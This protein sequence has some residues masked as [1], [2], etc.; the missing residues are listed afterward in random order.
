MKTKLSFM[1]LFIAWSTFAFAEDIDVYGVSNIKVKPNVLIILDNSGSMG[2]IDVPPPY[3]PDTSYEGRYPRNTV[4]K[5]NRSRWKKYF[6]GNLDNW[7][8]ESALTTLN[9]KGYWEGKLN[10]N[11]SLVNCSPG[12][13]VET[14]AMGNYVNYTENPPSPL[15]SRMEVAKD[16]VAD[17]IYQNK[18]KVKFGLMTFYRSNGGHLL[19]KCGADTNT[20]IGEYDPNKDSQMKD[21]KQSGLGVVGELESDGMTPV[22]ETMAEAGLYFAGKKSWFHTT[23][24]KTYDPDHPNKNCQGSDSVPSYYITHTSPIENRCQKNYIILVTDGAPTAD[25]AKFKDKNY[26]LDTKLSEDQE[27]DYKKSGYSSDA[28]IKHYS[29]LDDVAYFLYNTDILPD[30]GSPG[31]N[32][33]QNVKTYTIGFKQKLPLLL[34]TATRGGGKYYQ[35]SNA[36]ELKENLK[37]FLVEI[38][39]Q[40]E[41]FTATSV[42]INRANKAY[43]G[44][45][46]YYGLFQPTNDGNW[47]GNLKKYAITD[48]GII[49]DAEGDP[50]ESEGTVVETARSFWSTSADGIGVTSGGAGALLKD[51]NDRKLYTYTG[52]ARDLTDKSNEFG[53]DN[54]VL[55][56]GTYSD[57]TNKVIN[58]VHKG[59]YS[60]DNNDNNDWP[61]ASFLH[62]QPI[63]V[64]YYKKNEEGNYIFDQSMIY[65]GSN[66]GMMHCFN[67]DDGKEMWG[68][69]PQD[70]L[71]K[72]SR[73]SSPTSLEYFVDGTPVVYDY[74]YDDDNDP[75]TSDKNKKLLVFGER[76]GGDYYT[77]LD[78]SDYN[79][80]LFEYS[81]SPDILM[82]T[83]GQETLG[84]SW[85]I[86]QPLKMATSK[87]T[88]TDVFLMA[89]GYDTNQDSMSPEGNDTKGRAV[90]AVDTRSGNLFHN[91]LFSQ[92]NYTDMTHSIIAVSGFEN[93]KTKTTTRVYAG[94]LYG[95]LFAF[96]DDIFHWD[97][98]KKDD[99]GNLK[100]KFDGMEDGVWEQKLKL[101]A[102]P[103]RKIWHAPNIVNEYFPVNITYPKGDIND[104]EENTGD[105]TTKV[106]ISENRIGDYVFFGTGDRAH[107]ERKDLLNGFYAIKNNW[108]WDNDESPE[109]IEATV[110]LDG[111]VKNNAGTQIMDL[112]DETPTTD[113]WYILDVTNELIHNNEY[114]KKAID[115]QKNR[116]WFIRLQ[117]DNGSMMGE[118]VVSSPLIFNG[119]VYFS[120]YVPDTK[121]EADNEPDPCAISGA[122]GNGYLY[123]I[124]Y[125]YGESVINFDPTNDTL[126]EYGNIKEKLDRSDRRTIFRNKG[127]PPQP[128][129]VVHEGKPTIIAGF[130]TIDPLAPVGLQRA[131]W[132]QLN[133]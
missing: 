67:D 70:L 90:Y 47:F 84:Q 87:S 12:G 61:L 54:T 99:Q 19:A 2:R 10:K 9:S 71:G 78:I 118:K 88:T 104:T 89:G 85:S 8:C 92:F 11:D 131:F 5:K 116:G 1:L 23:T 96:R 72:V 43:A 46:V 73:L 41:V 36:E 105:S 7:K 59:I 65:A 112:K 69:I 60:D 100:D 111:K 32:E 24:C 74:W 38:E 30:E 120:T 68:F 42:P 91:F 122:E 101:Y 62:S 26:I 58:A 110:D 76:R 82:G 17:L 75:E 14:Y 15:S 128:V 127:I 49:Q 93:P 28:Y 119:V 86:P 48:S 126:D 64:H 53:T 50:I 117:E 57:I 115:H 98:D 27:D 121:T 123:A 124:G 94:D 3:N 20:L 25:D 107:P 56:D 35:A 52:T 103:G 66:G 81:I 83:T 114:V 37:S 130:E 39:A 129:L 13:Q 21:M 106:I 40:N 77:A 108:D 6:D 79:K 4:Y 97:T 45:F 51:R 29:F 132:R 31:D 102:V 63:V 109:I 33:K 95:N 18:E 113:K 44:N 80:P 125:K 34:T 133:N 55:T 16:V 22:A